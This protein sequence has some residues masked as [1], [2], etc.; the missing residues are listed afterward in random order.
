MKIKYSPNILICPALDTYRKIKMERKRKL[1][2]KNIISGQIFKYLNQM[3]W[4][5]SLKVKDPG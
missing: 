2:Y 4:N 5:N 3:K 1:S